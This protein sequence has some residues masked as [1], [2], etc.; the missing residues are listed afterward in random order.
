MLKP[1]RT[2]LALAAGSLV[3]GL[4]GAGTAVADEQPMAE[5]SS[6]QS[7]AAGMRHSIGK[8][9]S[10]GPLKVRSKPNTRS[11]AVGHVYPNR[12]VE[13]RCKKYG[14]A[15]DGNRLWYRL[16]N[17]RGSNQNGSD[18][19]GSNGNGSNGNSTWPSSTT[20]ATGTDADAGNDRAATSQRWVAARYVQNLGA[21]RF[22]R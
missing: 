22:C 16:Y 20:G 14:E 18:Q 8:V 7:A 5:T 17:D 21:V 12:T 4:V 9:V 3:L 2:I 1:T 10:Q 13:I 15:V 6:Q 11:R 19:N